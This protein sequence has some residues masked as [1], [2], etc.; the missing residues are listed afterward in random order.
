MTITRDDLKNG[1][2]FHYE[3]AEPGKVERWRSNGRVKEWVTRPDE[4]RA[5]IKHGL[6]DY[7]YLDHDSDLTLW[8]KESDCPLNK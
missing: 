5:P 6:R 4:F 8:H 7:F 2:V 1:G 3:P